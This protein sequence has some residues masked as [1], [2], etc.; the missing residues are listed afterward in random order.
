[1]QYLR[2]EAIILRRTNYGEAD[3]I[4]N[5]LTPQSGRVAAIAKG[6]RRP[7]SK[8]VGGLEL[9]AVCDITLAQGRGELLR[10]TG[11]RLQ[12]FFRGI[13]Q[14]YD[15]M[16]LGYQVVKRIAQATETV[17]EPEFYT[18]LKNALGYLNKPTI[19]WRITE[20]WFGLQLQHLLGEGLNVQTDVDGQ[21]LDEATS[22][23]FDQASGAFFKDKNGQFGGDHIKLLRLA[24]QT[25]PAVMSR[26]ASTTVD[27]ARDLSAFVR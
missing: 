1:M 20:V 4:L 23:G 12:E 16:Q 21:V 7:K 10:V 27:P 19:D 24:L 9:F 15:R 14:D 2:T 11:A 18:L 17:S 3:R 25:T 6:V 5:M 13:M 22:Y 26:V 8:L